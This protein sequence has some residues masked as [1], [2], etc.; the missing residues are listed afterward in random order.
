VRLRKVSGI[1]REITLDCGEQVIP[2]HEHGVDVEGFHE[3]RREGDDVASERS[4]CP[5]GEREVTCIF[6]MLKKSKQKNKE[7]T[8]IFSIFDCENG[9]FTWSWKLMWKMRVKVKVIKDY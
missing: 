1:E 5:S 3:E 4:A 8:L 2:L 9:D 7:V 6:V